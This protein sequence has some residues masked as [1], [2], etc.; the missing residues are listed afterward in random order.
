M[1]G[2]GGATAA[3]I[4]AKKSAALLS[5]G[6]T[7]TEAKGRGGNVTGTVYRK[8][9]A[10][11]D[12]SLDAVEKALGGTV[13]KTVT[14]DLNG[15]G[16][17][18]KGN[19]GIILTSRVQEA[20]QIAKGTASIAR[21]MA[22]QLMPGTSAQEIDKFILSGVRGKF[23]VDD[24]PGFIIRAAANKYAKDY[25]DQF[26]L[27]PEINSWLTKATNQLQGRSKD[28]WKSWSG[29]SESFGQAIAP[30]VGM[31]AG[32]FM[33][34]LSAALGGGITG[35]AAAGGLIGGGV[36]ALQGGDIGKG[37][38]SGAISGGF[39]AAS[40]Q[41]PGGGNF[42][43]PVQPSLVSPSS[44][45][46]AAGSALSNMAKGADPKAALASAAGG[47]A[48]G[49]INKY[50]TGLLRP[51]GLGRDLTGFLAGTAGGTAA[52]MIRGQDF[53]S[54][55][56]NAAVGSATNSVGSMVSRLAN[57]GNRDFDQTL[58]KTA[59]GLFNT[60]IKSALAPNT[61]TRPMQRPTG[62]M[63]GQAPMSKQ[64]QLAQMMSQMSPAQRQALLARL[65]AGRT[66]TPMP[67]RPMVTMPTMPGVAMPG[68][69]RVA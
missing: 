19:Q 48:G 54:A 40:S 52:G 37:M 62:M 28:I 13:R 14:R 50:A 43:G 24:N 30:Y 29:G 17:G 45:L 22:Q 63:A 8:T 6:W 55:L 18:R 51:Q 11:S 60:A 53:K 41:L 56:T 23:D 26:K 10:R 59:G 44:M 65:T 27:T 61:T 36:S 67:Q 21:Q 2:G 46:S 4:R 66:S 31:A 47:L 34:G 15:S 9:Y 20:A 42:V 64:Q 25:P 33:P 68:M 5:Q 57:T 1:P 38:L 69:P 35:G 58:G 49:A 3:R 12:P 16:G 7:K 32:A 39:G